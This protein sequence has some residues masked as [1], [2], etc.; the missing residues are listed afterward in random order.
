MNS[1]LRWKLNEF[2]FG[3][4]DFYGHDVRAADFLDCDVTIT[5]SSKLVYLHNDSR[6][7]DVSG[8]IQNNSGQW[9]QKVFCFYT[10]MRVTKISI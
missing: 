8:R 6:C 5:R 7:R 2:Q 1:P 4:P 9:S 3:I 10:M